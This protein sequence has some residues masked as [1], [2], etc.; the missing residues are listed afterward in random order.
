MSENAD[1]Q[2]KIFDPTPRRIRQ[3]RDE[4]QVAKSREIPTAAVVLAAGI[5]IFTTGQSIFA[6]L[7]NSTTH[8]FR[9][10]ASA[11]N[12][13]NG[14]I[15]GL[16]DSLVAVGMALIPF[17]LMVCGAALLGHIGQTGI[18]VAPK[19]IAPKFERINPFKRIKEVLGPA[20]AG[21]RT[22]VA[23]LKMLFIGVV[24][25]MVAA[26]E[27]AAVQS[28]AT[29]GVAP[30]L[31]GLGSACVRVMLSAGIA[32][33]VPA[34]IDFTW[35]RHKHNKQLKMTR[36]EIKKESR[37]DEGSPEMKGKRKQMH[38][39]LTLNRVLEE[40]PN[41]DV[42]VTN[43]THFAVAL[44]YEQGVD[45]APRVVAKGTDAMAMTIRRIARQNSVPIVENRRLART[46]HRTVKVGRSVP[47]ELFAAVA[48]VLAYV[49]RLKAR[50]QGGH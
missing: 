44:R 22:G 27:L 36:E 10:A 7:M 41:A 33:C 48:E 37:E 31:M 18:L 15:S 30:M 1:P 3:A 6:A 50:L 38:R 26:D 21:M 39:E 28:A 34:L 35:Q 45:F 20:N 32:F 16:T 14:A 40:V 8:T 4:G 12:D 17:F 42:I 5:A 49:Y 47:N 9:N 43:P 24:V 29:R 11:S 13:L 25:G 19:A 2:A 46:L 23:L